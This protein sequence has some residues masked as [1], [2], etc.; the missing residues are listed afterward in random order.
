M[1][2]TTTSLLLL[3][4]PLALGVSACGDDDGGGDTSAGTTPPTEA[5]PAEGSADGTTVE[6][7]EFAFSPAELEVP[8]GASV[9]WT[10]GD[11]FAHTAQADDGTFDTGDIAAGASSDPVTFEEPGTYSYFCGIHNSMTAVITVVE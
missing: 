6:I 3:S 5:A 4:I 8:V 2:R 9:V 7:A 1:R 11:E 10:N